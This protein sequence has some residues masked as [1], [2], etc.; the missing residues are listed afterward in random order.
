MQRTLHLVRKT[1]R[2]LNYDYYILREN[3]RPFLCASNLRKHFNIPKNAIDLQLLVSTTPIKGTAR[4]TFNSH[5]IIRIDKQRVSNLCHLELMSQLHSL[6][7]DD[8]PIA[9][10]WVYFTYIP[11]S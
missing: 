1:S 5:H 2:D 6:L 3:S 9:R 8:F 7:P 10:L 11:H 4:I